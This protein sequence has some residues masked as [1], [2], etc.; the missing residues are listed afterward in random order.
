M[1]FFPVTVSCVIQRD[2]ITAL[3]ELIDVCRSIGVKKIKFEFERIYSE[4]SVAQSI[5]ELAITSGDIPLFLKEH[6]RSYSLNDL[7]KNL[8]ACLVSGKKSGIYIAFDPPFLMDK[9]EKCYQGMLR[10]E[11][12]YFCLLCFRMPHITPEGDLIY[13]FAARKSFGNILES[14]LEEIW[15]SEESKAYRRKLLRNNL[16]SLCENCPYMIPYSETDFMK[17]A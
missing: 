17:D 9:L 6:A 14:P 10:S 2:N 5:E 15:N 4:K 13:C 1:P 12:Q 7:Q 3:L 11:R 8:L 16:M